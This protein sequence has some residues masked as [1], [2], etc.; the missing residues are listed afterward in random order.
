MSG[1]TRNISDGPGFV[2]IR[3]CQECNNMLYPKEDKEI[4]QLGL[5]WILPASSSFKTTK[6]I[7]Y[8]AHAIGNKG[9][10]SLTSLLI[11]ESLANSLKT[12]CMS[13]M[14][15]SMDRFFITINLT[16]QGEK[17]YERVIEYVY[18]FIN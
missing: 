3:F 15:E 2:G 18:K 17:V 9:E 8:L 10:N 11:K 13:R 16:E 6:S 4:K 12:S 1:A 7:D 5:R 14:N